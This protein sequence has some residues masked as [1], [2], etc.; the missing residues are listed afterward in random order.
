MD[1]N[2]EIVFFLLYSFTTKK[3]FI[4]CK[5]SILRRKL[6]LKDSLSKLIDA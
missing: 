5:K 4:L 6:F 3:I 1:E 2:S